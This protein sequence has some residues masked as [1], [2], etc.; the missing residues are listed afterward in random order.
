MKHFMRTGTAV[1]CLTLAGAAAALPLAPGPLATVT[2]AAVPDVLALAT[3]GTRLLVGD[4]VFIR[5]GGPG[6]FR[7]VAAAT[8]SWTNHVGIVVDVAGAEPLIAESAVPL[9][10]LTPLSRFAARS[11][12]GRLAVRRLVVEPTAEERLLVSA[13]AQGRLGIFYDTGFDLHSRRR[14]FCSRYVREVLLEATGQSVGEV[15]TFAGLLARRPQAGLGFWKVWYFGR[16]PWQRETVTPASVL[17]SSE[18]RPIFDGV[19]SINR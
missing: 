15:E 12:G 14:Q 18:L 3:L 10:R 1:A 9:S 16:I 8:G 17:E 11:E 7:E 2:E 6:P 4:L 13:A 5:I 19:A